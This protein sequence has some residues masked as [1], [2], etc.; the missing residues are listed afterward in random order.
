MNDQE[1]A[2]HLREWVKHGGKGGLFAWPTDSCVY[3]QHIKFVDYRN[4]NWT[5]ERAQRQSFSDFVLEYADKLED[6]HD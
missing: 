4:A 2:A 1:T 5:Q 3:E 6:T